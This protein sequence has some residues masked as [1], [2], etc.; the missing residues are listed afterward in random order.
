MPRISQITWLLF[1]WKVTETGF[2]PAGKGKVEQYTPSIL[3][4]RIPV[5]AIAALGSG[6][7]PTQLPQSRSPLTGKVFPEPSEN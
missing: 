2:F 3:S 5:H 4:D 1:V 6:R 7:G